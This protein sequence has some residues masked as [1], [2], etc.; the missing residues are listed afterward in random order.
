MVGAAAKMLKKSRGAKKAKKA[1]GE[2]ISDNYKGGKRVP[3][4]KK[5][6]AGPPSLYSSA[7]EE[8]AYQYIKSKREN[9]T[10]KGR[11]AIRRSGLSMS[12]GG[13]KDPRGR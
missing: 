6:P 3:K 13:F 1:L 12:R 10:R 2:Y 9:R 11:A 4:K 8:R 7:S 5:E